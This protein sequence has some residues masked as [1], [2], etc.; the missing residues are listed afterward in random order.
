MLCPIYAVWHQVKV[1]SGKVCL[2]EP[3]WHWARVASELLPTWTL[4]TGMGVI[5]GMVYLSRH[6]VP[7]WWTS[8]AKQFMLN[9]ESSAF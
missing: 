3:E 1:I 2:F 9:S 7:D 4:Y 8:Q 6:T 5:T